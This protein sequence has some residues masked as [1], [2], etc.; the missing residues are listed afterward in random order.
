MVLNQIEGVFF[1]MD[2]TLL[3]TLD[4]ICDSINETLTRWGLPNKSNETLLHYIGWG[5]KHLCKGATGFEDEAQLE[6]FHKEYRQTSLNRN[7]PKT[8]AYRGIPE[9]V[10][11]LKASGKKVGIYTN[12]PQAWTEKLAAHYFGEKV[13]DGI[14]GVREGGALKPSPEGITLMCAE[15]GIDPAKTVMIGDSPVDI[16][17]AHNAGIIGIGCTW[18]F[19]SKSQLEAAGA[20]YLVEDANALAQL[21]GLSPVF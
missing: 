5:A 20:N 12:K 6:A 3:N 8:V 1:D 15:W 2:G 14:Y 11:L 7:D 10:S 21:F 4:D 16:E 17:T 19:R 13:F 18:G 9:V